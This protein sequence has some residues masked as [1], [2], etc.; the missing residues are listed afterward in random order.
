MD[1]SVRQLGDLRELTWSHV[2]FVLA[3]VVGCRLLIGIVRWCVHRAAESAP[4]HWRLSILR[5]APLATLLIAIA[6]IAIIIP[7]LVEPTFDDIVALIAT[8]ALA[9]AFALKD[10]V[11]SLAAGIVTI[12]EN[13][14]QPGDWIEVD[15]AYGEV[16]TIATRAVHIVTADDT[17]VIIPHARLWSTSVFNA[18]S[19]SHSLLCVANFYLAADHD[20]AAVCKTLIAIAETS[21]YRR[22]DTAVKV[23]A[24]ELPWGTRYK[25]KAYVRDSRDQFAMITDLTI[26]GKEQLRAMHI[27]FAQ[28]PYA[29]SKGS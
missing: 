2:L 24:A 17:E 20:G 4:S 28:A 29:E 11:S 8:V 25:V 16:K 21:G 22:Q 13:T 19:G 5:M 10:Y 1:E 27:T 15:G 7:I 6:G 23:V 18:S 9:L 26:R 3:I 14:Y 12:L